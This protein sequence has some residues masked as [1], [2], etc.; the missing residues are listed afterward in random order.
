MLKEAVLALL[1]REQGSVLKPRVIGMIFCCNDCFD[2]DVST[3]TTQGCLAHAVG[4][5]SAGIQGTWWI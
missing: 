2:S 1:S 3:K 5:P 4:T